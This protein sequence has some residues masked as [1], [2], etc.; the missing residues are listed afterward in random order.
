M[1]PIHQGITSSV[2]LNLNLCLEVDC[3]KSLV[4]LGLLLTLFVYLARYVRAIQQ[5][6]SAWELSHSSPPVFDAEQ[7]DAKRYLIVHADDAGMSH[8]VNRATVEGLER[9]V[10]SSASIMVPCPWFP[11]FAKYARENPERDC[12]IHLTLN[13]EWSEYRWGPVTDRKQVPSLV[14]KDGFL[15]DNVRQVV[16]NVKLA[17][18]ATE[19]RAQ[20]QRAKDFGVP[21][22]HLDPHMGAALSRPDLGKLYIELA[23]ENEIPVL[24]VRPTKENGLAEQYPDLIRILPTLEEREL[25]ILSALYQFYDDGPYEKRKQKYLDTIRQLPPGTSEII[26]HCGFNDAELQAITGS[27]M[28]RDSDRRVFTDPEVRQAIDDAGIELSTWKQFHQRQKK[29]MKKK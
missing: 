12:G 13:S 20:I 27:V 15:W 3:M 23:V 16:A 5:V 28:I 26:I 14:D 25:P 11:E 24:F 8:S 29:Q 10:V 18:A 22:T 4:W 19:L 1:I 9:G 21:V 2:N 6:P 17:E 7:E